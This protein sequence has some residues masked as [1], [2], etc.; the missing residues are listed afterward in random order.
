ME[1]PAR[2]VC[3]FNLETVFRNERFCKVVT[4]DVGRDVARRD[5]A[6]DARLVREADSGLRVTERLVLCSIGI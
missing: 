6:L 5:A 3:A 4:V 2:W 1:D